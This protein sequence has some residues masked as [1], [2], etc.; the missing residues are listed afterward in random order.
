[1]FHN[2]TSPKA[3][4]SSKPEKKFFL[5]SQRELSARGREEFNLKFSRAS[6]PNGSFFSWIQTIGKSSF[7]IYMYMTCQ[8]LEE[9]CE[10]VCGFL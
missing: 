9:L 10:I 3:I 7:I 5:K 1:M 4:Y 8:L 6:I 2:K